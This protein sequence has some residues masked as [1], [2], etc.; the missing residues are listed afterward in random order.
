MGGWSLE[1]DCKGERM[2]VRRSV[3][4]KDLGIPEMSFKDKLWE[5]VGPLLI[6]VN[7]LSALLHRR[8]HHHPDDAETQTDKFKKKM[9][10]MSRIR[11]MQYKVV[12]GVIKLLA[13]HLARI[14]AKEFK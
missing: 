8:Q 11:L 1:A 12:Q 2:T 9:T 6:G 3:L 13:A 4:H 14:P 10:K 5:A 7:G